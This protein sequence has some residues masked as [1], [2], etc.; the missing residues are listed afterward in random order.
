[1]GEGRF[2]NELR[3]RS[4]SGR[5]WYLKTQL[6]SLRHADQLYLLPAEQLKW[7]V[8]EAVGDGAPV[9]GETAFVGF[10]DQSTL[11]YRGQGEDVEGRE[12]VLRL[13]YSLSTPADAPA[14]HYIG[15]LLFTMAESP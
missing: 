13:Q 9:G 2:F 10:S 12:V 14:G 3:C 11:L 5:P 7:R 15:Q 4:N 8:A 6:V 1:M